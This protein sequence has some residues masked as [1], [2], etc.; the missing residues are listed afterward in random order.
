[1]VE[2]DGVTIPDYDRREFSDLRW[3]SWDA[4]PYPKTDRHMARCMTKL[5]GVTR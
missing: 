3:F 4:L 2:A 1:L 5:E